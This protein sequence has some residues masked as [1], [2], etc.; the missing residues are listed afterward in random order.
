TSRRSRRACARR[1][2]A[3]ASL[4]PRYDASR[5]LGEYVSKYY[6]PAARQGQRYA[7]EGYQA[8]KTIAAWK[9][10]VRAAGPGVA[11]RRAD[12]PPRR[13]LFGETLPVEIAVKLNCLAPADLYLQLIRTP[14]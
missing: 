14:E 3:M 12:T 13:I 10:R 5:M 9:A 8:A 4:L 11:V 6:L 1:R 2:R 7:R